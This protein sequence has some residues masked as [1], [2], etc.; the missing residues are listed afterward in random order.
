VSVFLDTAV[1]MYARGTDHPLREPCRDLLR[2][3]AEQRLAAVTS[4]EVVQEILH[5]YLAVR[6]ST[7][8]LLVAREVISGFGPLLP[9]THAVIERMPGLVERYPRL[10]SRDLIHVATCLEEGVD[11]IASPD[12]GFDEVAEIRRLDPQQGAGV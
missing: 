3:I 10:T 6:R 7:K 2:D 8:G 12:R 11:V 4:V 5:R 9:V 1:F